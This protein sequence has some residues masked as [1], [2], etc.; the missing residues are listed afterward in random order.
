MR[1]LETHVFDALIMRIS[2]SA[3][4]FHVNVILIRSICQLF[5]RN[6]TKYECTYREESPKFKISNMCKTYI[7]R[8]FGV[9]F[10]RLRSQQ[11]R[12]P[13]VRILNEN[14]LRKTH[15]ILSRL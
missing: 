3:K 12:T 9:Y 8:I 5:L 11:L 13:I 2:H 4:V 14:G 15:C 10:F 1:G 7:W 6:P